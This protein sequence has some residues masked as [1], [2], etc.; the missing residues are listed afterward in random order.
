VNSLGRDP[1]R[2]ELAHHFSVGLR[3]GFEYITDLS[4][5]PD[6]WPDLLGIEPGSRWNEP[7]DRARLALRLLGRKTEMA[8]TLERIEPDRLVEYATTQSGL[9]EAHHERHFADDGQGGLDYRLVVEY[10]PRRG[11]RGLFDRLV[12]RRGIRRALGKTVSNLEAS[13]TAQAR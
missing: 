10:V 8:M 3:E 13:F 2:V 7:G 11:A 1:V 6:Y 5:W 9:P 12:L 4:N